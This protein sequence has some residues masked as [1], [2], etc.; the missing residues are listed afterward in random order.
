MASHRCLEEGLSR[1]AHAE[2]TRH[3]QAA[4]ALIRVREQEA[5]EKESRS[6]ISS[7]PSTRASR[8]VPGSLVGYVMGRERAVINDISRQTRTQITCPVKGGPPEFDIEGPQLCV[9]AASFCIEAKL[10]LAKGSMMMWQS[11]WYQQE[12]IEIRVPSDRVGFVVGLMG[13]V[14]NSIA[15]NTGTQIVSPKKGHDPVFVVTGPKHSVLRA[16]A[17]IEDKANGPKG[18]AGQLHGH[19]NRK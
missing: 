17:A 9:E 10:H 12:T 14:I 6:S 7:Q 1:L 18:S 3:S 15:A 2:L 11:E 19:K 4:V 16:K 5:L 8:T 13:S